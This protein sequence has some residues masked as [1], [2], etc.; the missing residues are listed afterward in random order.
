M[1]HEYFDNFYIIYINDILIYNK[2]KKKNIKYIR[3]NLTRFRE[4]KLQI[5]V[6]KY[7]FIIIKIK[8]FDLIIIIKDV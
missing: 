5:D 3:F 6:Q 4:T 1:L 7:L 2:S 8:Y